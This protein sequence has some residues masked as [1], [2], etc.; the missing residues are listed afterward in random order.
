MENENE[1]KNQNAGEGVNENNQ[2]DNAEGTGV[3]TQANQNKDEGNAI[4]TFTQ[5][6][7]NAMLKKE[8]QKAE[9]KYEGIDIN[10]YNEWLESQ[11]TAEQKKAE[12]ETRYQKA[13][14]DI[15]EKNNYIAVLE[16]GVS[17]DDSDYVLFKVSR[18]D[19]DF[20]ENLQSFLKDNPKFLKSEEH[21]AQNQT[22]GV[23]V[24][25]INNNSSNGV[26]A[27]L[28]QKHPDLFK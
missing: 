18:M 22:T 1:N 8:K 11:K 7:V 10:K 13:L 15:Q 28:K 20:E 3:G 27:I 25:T 17:K 21:E 26:D 12:K 23:S 2:K 14:S 6:E 5:D 16:S 19:G 4:K 9:K 24:K